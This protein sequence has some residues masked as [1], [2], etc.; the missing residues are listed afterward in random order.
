MRLT[1]YTDYSLRVLLYLAKHPDKSVTISE[2][3]D[4]YQISRNHLVKVVHHLGLAGYIHTTRGRT[5]GITLAKTADK[6]RI[7]DVIRA[8]EPD[9]DLLECFNPS[10]DQCVITNACR[11]KGVLK[12]AQIEFMNNLNKNTLADLVKPSKKLAAVEVKLIPTKFK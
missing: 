7:G 11:L 12:K 5:G 2:L 10:T 4:F 3:A 1:V 6:I 9:L 8:T